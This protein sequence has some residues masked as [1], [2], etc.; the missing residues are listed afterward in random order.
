M[1]ATGW[2]SPNLVELIGVKNS[3]I[4]QL[5]KILTPLLAFLVLTG[6]AKSISIELSTGNTGVSLD[7]KC[8][9]DLLLC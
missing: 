7:K 1:Q 3:L 6:S 2:T 5:R 8:R 9:M 4:C